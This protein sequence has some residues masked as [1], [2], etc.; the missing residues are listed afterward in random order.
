MA[1]ARWSQ[2]NWYIW[3]DCDGYLACHHIKGGLFA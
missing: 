3:W 2:G 1:Y